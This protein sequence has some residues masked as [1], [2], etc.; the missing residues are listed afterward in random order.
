MADYPN[1]IEGGYGGTPLAH[2]I[3]FLFVSY[4]AVSPHKLVSHMDHS[5]LLMP[6][7]F[8]HTHS[9]QMHGSYEE[10]D[11]INQSRLIKINYLILPYLLKIL[12]SLL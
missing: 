1:G 8:T 9:D 10:H 6:N 11:L 2:P 12:A 5:F 7:K 3:F 4:A